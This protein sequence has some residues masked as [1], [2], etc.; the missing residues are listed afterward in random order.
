M[1]NPIRLFCFF[2]IAGDLGSNRDWFAVVS[3]WGKCRMFKQI[4]SVV[5]FVTLGISVFPGK[6]KVVPIDSTHSVSVG[7]PQRWFLGWVPPCN[8]VPGFL[9]LPIFLISFMNQR[10][11]FVIDSSQSQDC[12]VTQQVTSSP[13]GLCC[14]G[15]RL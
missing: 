7:L 12:G 6:L 14:L 3:F 1:G 11:S 15:R 10:K 5:A 4:T 9:G 13:K 8:G 2:Q